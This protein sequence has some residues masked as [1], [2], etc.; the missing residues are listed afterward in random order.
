MPKISVITP[1]YNGETY[2][3]NAIESLLAQS[4]QDWDLIV[5]NDG[6]T[7][8]TAQILEKYTADG[9]IKVVHQKNSGEA[10][11]RN[12]GLDDATGEYIAFLD[13]DDTYFPNA[14][15]DLSSFLDAHP[16]YDVVYSDGLICD[17]DDNLV[18]HLNE[19]RPGFF[20]GRILEQ[21]VTSSSVIT[22]PICTMVRRARVVSCAARFDR[23]LIIGPDWDFW[24]QLAVHAEFGF[25]D[26]VTCK[27]RVHNMNITKRVDLKKRRQDQFFGRSKVMNSTWF[28]N[29]SV[30]TR[31]DFFLELLTNILSGNAEMQTAILK[32]QQVSALP[33][34]VRSYLWRMAGIDVLQNNAD[35]SHAVFYFLES[36]KNNPNDRKTRFVLWASRVG[37]PFVLGFIKIWRWTLQRGHRPSSEAHSKSLQLQK[38]FGLK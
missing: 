36:I 5:V 22:V 33:A 2:I 37:R 35:V 23:N 27:Y 24:I 8:A 19:V 9:R 26:K 18:M 17:S 29:L 7:D 34:D 32:S 11:A 12:V 21:L 4:C 6:S 38:I 25:L 30:Q 1:V 28:D 31:Q 10:S 13:A 14:L 15:E 16:R 3:E 20:S